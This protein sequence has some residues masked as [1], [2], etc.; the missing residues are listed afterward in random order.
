VTKKAI[1]RGALAV[2]IY[3]KDLVTAAQSEAQG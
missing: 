3:H 2:D 1:P